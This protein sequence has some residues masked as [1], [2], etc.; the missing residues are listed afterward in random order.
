MSK[1]TKE[2][3]KTIEALEDL[4]AQ[5]SIINKLSQNLEEGS[6]ESHHLKAIEYEMGQQ[7]KSLRFWINSLYSYNGKSTS[8]A[9]QNASKENGKKGGR[10]PKE[11]TQMKKRLVTLEEL[12]ENARQEKI[13]TTDLE[14]EAKLTE[15]LKSYED[16]RIL[17]EEKL[18]KWKIERKSLK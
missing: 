15:E 4:Q 13:L 18:E 9:K 8:R 7:L 1:K 10:P 5:I 11:I 12:S 17:I 2:I 16:E 6:E 14:K 3:Y